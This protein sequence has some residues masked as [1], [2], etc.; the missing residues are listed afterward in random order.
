VTV[1]ELTNQLAGLYRAGKPFRFVQRASA[2]L[3]HVPVAP[4]LAAL[5]LRALVDLGYGGPAREL[6][7]LRRDLCADPAQEKSLR[8]ALA[9]LPDGRI[10]WSALAD[11]YQRNLAIV[12]QRW[13]RIA[14]LLAAASDRLIATHLY[15][16]RFGAY[17]LSA[18]SPGKIRNWIAPLSTAE[19]DADVRLPERGKVPA[20][21]IVGA[22]TGAIVSALWQRTERLFLTYSQPIYLIEPDPI[23]LAA[24]LHV[25][26]HERT[27]ADP[28]LML[29][30]GPAAVDDFAHALAENPAL[31][32]PQ[33]YVDLAE[34]PQ[35]AATVRAACERTHTQRNHDLAAVTRR[36]AERHAARDSAWWAQRWRRPAPVLA[37]T[38]RFTTVLQYAARDALA[39]LRKLG[40]PTHLLIEQADHEQLSAQM[41]CAAV[42]RIDPGLILML[43]HLRYEAPHLPKNVP[44]LTWIQDPLPNLMCRR[45]G[46]SIGPLDFVCGILKARCVSE[47]GYPADRFVSLEMPVSLEMFHDGPVAPAAR[48]RYACDLC[49]VSNA[50]TTLAQLQHEAL[51]THPPRL[52][53]LLE[54]LYRR[55]LD[56]LARGE[57]PYD[58]AFAMTR[59]AAADCGVSLTDDELHKLASFHAYRLLDWGRRHETL[60]WAAD[61]AARTSR[62]LRIY[63]RGWENHPTLA[64]HAAGEI[65]HG[66]PLRQ[67]IASA[68][69]ALQLIPSG[70]RHQRSYEILACGTLPL[71]RHCARDFASLP[72]AEYVRRRDAGE[73]PAGDSLFPG[74]ERIAFETRDQ[75]EALAEHYLADSVA[76]ATVTADLRRVVLEHCTFDAAMRKVLAAIQQQLRTADNRQPALAAI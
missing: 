56:M 46:E 8:A 74:L 70:F 32:I 4:E 68:R 16:S 1:N 11:N 25:E 63:G 3:H 2:A 30:A 38:S 60:Q 14:D 41:V 27:I 48:A 58:A 40:H 54:L 61:W 62:T 33:L 76:R 50:S 24:W 19:N 13:P 65:A 64:P 18:E 21:A 37:I 51:A 9:E 22:R 75:F 73:N 55:A 34:A 39:A 71:T 26:N 47:Y 66:E 49:F 35:V 29:F 45:A 57:F 53:P 44:V 31:P 10:A 12:Q 59:S 15:R 72:I 17:H 28:R 5:T 23:C 7:E 42:E 6:L 20:P 69:I 52:H 43:D 67:A 36:L